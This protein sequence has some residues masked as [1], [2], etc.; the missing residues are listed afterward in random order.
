[1]SSDVEWHSNAHVTLFSRS[2][3]VYLPA[4]SGVDVSGALSTIFSSLAPGGEV[5]VVAEQQGAADFK[6][7]LLLGGYVDIAE[8]KTAEVLTAR[9]PQW[10]VGAVAAVSVSKQQAPQVATWKLAVDDVADDE[11]VDE[12]SLLDDGLL[13]AVKKPVASAMD[14]CGPGAGGKKRACKNCTCGRAE[15]EVSGAPTMSDEEL[16]ASVSSCGNCYKGDAFRCSGCP[17]LGLPAFEPGQE[18]LVLKV[19][20][21]A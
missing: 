4:G 17:Y 12:D 15:Q 18:K 3:V 1:M 20:Q 16:K 6:T 7:A 19:A 13:S 8:G 21:D 11:L 9:K 2:Q 5:S 10:E 14:D